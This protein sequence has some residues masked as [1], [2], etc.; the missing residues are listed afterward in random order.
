MEKSNPDYK[1][2]YNDIIDQKYPQKRG[3][4]RNILNKPQLDVLDIIQINSIIFDSKEKDTQEFNHKH[5]SYDVY[6]IRKIL[7]YQKKEK[8]NNS[9]VSRK[10]KLSR[11]TIA[12]WKKFFPA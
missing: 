10:F 1:R 4:C 8:L 2:I 7:N 12:K 11:N 6:S 3:L 5:R 9:E